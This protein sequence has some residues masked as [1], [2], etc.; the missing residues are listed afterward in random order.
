MAVHQ[1][2]LDGTE[3]VSLARNSVSPCLPRAERASLG[4]RGHRHEQAFGPCAG[5][6][7]HVAFENSGS[8]ANERLRREPAV[9]AGVWR[10]FAGERWIAEPRFAQAGAGRLDYSRVE[11]VRVRSASEILFADTTGATTARKRNR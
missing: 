7:G 1:G 8:P 9:D 10:R 6:V 5:H 3:P 4:Y 11:N 2:S